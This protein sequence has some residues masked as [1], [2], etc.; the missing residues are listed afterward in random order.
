MNRPIEFR[1][2]DKEEE[3]MRVVSQ[4]DFLSKEVL[5]YDGDSSTGEW[6][7][8]DFIELLQSTGL[9]DKNG[10]KIFEGDIVKTKFNIVVIKY[11]NTAF[12][13]MRNKDGK[14]NKVTNWDSVLG[15]EIIGSIYENPELLEAQH[16]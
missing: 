10:K 8:F 13:P 11:K 1:A 2:W 14:F 9:K 7:N 12:Y 15:G 4:I 6:C 3:R 5:F 16:D